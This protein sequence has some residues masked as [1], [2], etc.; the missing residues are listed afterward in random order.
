MLNGVLQL[1][2]HP[3]FTIPLVVRQSPNDVDLII[4]HEEGF[5]I[6]DGTLRLE[7]LQ[8]VVQLCTG[9]PAGCGSSI[10]T[11]RDR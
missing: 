9:C 1:G 8:K 7:D 10:L 4:V 3:V 2:Y 11:I 5:G 6:R